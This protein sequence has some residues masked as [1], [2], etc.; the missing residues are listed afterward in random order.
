LAIVDFSDSPAVL[1]GNP[2]GV[3]TFFDETAFIEDQGAVRA[4]EIIINKTPILGYYFIIGPWRIAHKPLHGPDITVFHGQ[5]DR[6]DGFAFEFTELPG[7]VIEKMFP[8]FASLKAVGKLFVESFE[9]IAE[10]FNIAFAKVKFW[11]WIKVFVTSRV[12]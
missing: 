12:G 6:L 7:H 9:F 3:L 5:G 1:A 8:G 11:D 4:A 2:D 10:T